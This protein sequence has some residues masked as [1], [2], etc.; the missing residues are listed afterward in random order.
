M[1]PRMICP[2]CG[3]GRTKHYDAMVGSDDVLCKGT[4]DIAGTVRCGC[5]LTRWQ[6]EQRVAEREGHH[7]HHC[8]HCCPQSTCPCPL[9]AKR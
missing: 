6:I 2:A 3:H 9:G 1:K 4:T 8:A 7:G 5:N